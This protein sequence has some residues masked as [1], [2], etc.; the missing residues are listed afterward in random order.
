MREEIETNKRRFL[1][2]VRQ[3]DASAAAEI[4]LDDA[5]LVTPTGEVIRGRPGIERFWRG[6]LDVGLQV[7]ELDLE[8]AAYGEE[9]ATEIG[10]YRFLVAR[11]TGGTEQD[12][13]FFLLADKRMADGSWKRAVDMFTSPTERSVPGRA[14]Q[15]E[16][17][18][19]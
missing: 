18:K 12:R 15:K 14:R 2:A 4:Y 8:Q 19:Q 16:E 6:G 13:G 7:A 9:L 3:G 10:R 11:E 17:T 5:T 1:E